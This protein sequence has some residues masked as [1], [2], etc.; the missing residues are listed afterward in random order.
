MPPRRRKSTAPAKPAR[1]PVGVRIIG[2][3]L[4]GRRLAY[5]GDA[6]T[7]P[8]KDRL[9]E[10]IFN[11]IGPAVKGLH[12]VDLFAGTGALG[13]EAIS[14]GAARATLIEQH[15]PTAN[16]IGQS[17]AELGLDAICEVVAADTFIWW[18]RGPDLGPLPQVIFCSPPYDLY[19]TRTADMVELVTGLF[20]AA[21]AGSLLVVEADRRFD[22]AL[23][24]EAE[25]AD[26]RSY[27]PAVVGLLQKR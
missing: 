2:G 16:L 25:S 22:F 13:L 3:R 7:R 11:L 14:R 27:P 6:R 15:F 24:P 10:A 26:V 21:P 5:S 17:V 23:L 20:R 9:R 1:Q 12:A 18:R 19:V 4:R 8:M